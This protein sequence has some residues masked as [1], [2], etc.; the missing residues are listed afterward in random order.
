MAKLRVSLAQMQIVAGDTARNLRTF[1]AMVT[2]AGRRRSNV[3]VFPELWHTGYDLANAKETADELNS[4][5]FAQIADLA[6]KHKVA[7]VGS[8]LEKRGMTVSNSTTIYAPNGSLYGVYRK[9]HLFRLMEEDK[10]LMEGPSPLTVKLPWGTTGVAI[11]Y[12]LRFPELFRRYAIEEGARVIIVSAEWP[13]ERIQHWRTLLQARAVENQCIMV[14]VNTAGQSG[15]TVFGGHSM[16]VDPWGE[17][18]VEAGDQPQLITADVEM[19]LVDEV[20]ARIPV[21]DDLRTDI[22]R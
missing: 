19:D 4:G 6:I 16:I 13:T 7:I 5:V 15:D 11:C 21:F 8:T 14:G 2:E 9:L 1:E 17:I 12:D 20:R 22:Y 10:W 18:V 3:V